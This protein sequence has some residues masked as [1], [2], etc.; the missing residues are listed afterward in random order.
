MYKSY[1]NFVNT[2]YAITY[3]SFILKFPQMFV[4]ISKLQCNYSFSLTGVLDSTWPFFG[5]EGGKVNDQTVK[6]K[7]QHLNDHVLN[8]R[9]IKLKNMV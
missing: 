9:F 8:C 1:V 2:N 3:H 7:W 4:C 6:K 5:T